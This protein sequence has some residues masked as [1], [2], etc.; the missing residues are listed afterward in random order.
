MRRWA[1][2]LVGYE[3]FAVTTGRK[4]KTAIRRGFTRI[5]ADQ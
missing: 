4:K 3:E 5:L 2:Y 1:G